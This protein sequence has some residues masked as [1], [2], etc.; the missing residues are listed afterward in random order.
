[1]TN[2][3]LIIGG[4]VAAAGVA[5]Y[6]LFFRESDSW[7]SYGSGLMPDLGLGAGVAPAPGLQKQ[8]IKKPAVPAKATVPYEWDPALGVPGWQVDTGFGGGGYGG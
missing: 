3:Q 1:V 7:E 2:R 6:L 8:K 4:L 5:A